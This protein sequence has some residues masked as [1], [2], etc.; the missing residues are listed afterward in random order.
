[1]LFGGS[2][3]VEMFARDAKFEWSVFALPAP[4]GRETYII[5]EPDTGVGINKSSPYKEEA[6]LFL[7]WLMTDGV[8]A[9][10]KYLPGRYPLIKTP[11]Q[12]NTVSAV[13]YDAA[14]SKLAITYPSDIRW[15]SA[16]ADAQYPRSSEI[17]RQALYEMIHPKMIVSEVGEAT[18][19]YLTAQEAAQ[20][21]QTGLGEW[22]IPA[23]ICR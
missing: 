20:R 1:M 4:S 12:A 21:L 22:Y 6:K 16:A 2:W 23:Q 17:V 15:M 19:V 3:D 13:G 18:T 14:F 11:E 10:E 9:S 8:D 7:Q 5:F